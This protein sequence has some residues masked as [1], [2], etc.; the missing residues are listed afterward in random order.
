VGCL[1]R[2]SPA[3]RFDARDLLLRNEGRKEGRKI[4]MT[5]S[6][7][8]W[9]LQPVRAT[10]ACICESTGH[11]LPGR[12]PDNMPQRPTP[13]QPPPIA[14][15]VVSHVT[16]SFI[17]RCHEEEPDRGGN[18]GR[19]RR[20]RRCASNP[21]R[22]SARGLPDLCR[23]EGGGRGGSACPAERH[24]HTHPY[25]IQAGTGAEERRRARRPVSQPPSHPTTVDKQ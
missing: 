6:G 12:A 20:R 18:G 23:S 3:T 24:L 22:R 7:P 1:L 14:P 2:S 13:C 10:L 8:G 4:V 25:T 9:V 17:S 5:T 16:R 15:Q 11:C 21:R 19:R